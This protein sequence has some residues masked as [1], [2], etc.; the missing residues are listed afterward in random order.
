M[1][2][3]RLTIRIDDYLFEKI[4]SQVNL[5]GLSISR[6]IRQALFKTKLPTHKFDKE[7]VY[8]LS[9]VGSNLNQLVYKMD[10]KECQSNENILKILIE[11]YNVL[12]EISKNIGDKTW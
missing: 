11:I 6:Y 3:H 8:K 4:K 9:E 7:V 5:T 10:N 12:N 1:L 2:K